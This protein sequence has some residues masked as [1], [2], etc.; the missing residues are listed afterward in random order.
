VCYSAVDDHDAADKI[1]L[2]VDQPEIEA[3]GVVP[4]K[5][6]CG[7]L[8]GNAVKLSSPGVPNRL[9]R[10]IDRGLLRVVSGPPVPVLHDRWS[11]S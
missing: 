3:D 10:Q 9:G 8:P 2:R 11:S 5:A 6:R 4:P 1:D 7:S